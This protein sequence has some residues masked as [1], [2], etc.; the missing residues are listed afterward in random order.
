MNHRHDVV[1]GVDG[2]PTAHAALA[3]GAW[4]AQRRRQLL[5]LVHCQPIMTPYATWGVG[6]NPAELAD[7]DVATR[8]LLDDAQAGVEQALPDLPVE[9]AALVGNPAGLLVEA[10][11]EADLVVVGSRGL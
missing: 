2:S 8:A 10:S 3:H 4:E 11:A 5:R 7:Q 1:V 6:P 9:T